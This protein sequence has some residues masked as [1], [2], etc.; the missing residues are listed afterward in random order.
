MEI[1]VPQEVLD[2]MMDKMDQV[3]AFLSRNQ[4]DADQKRAMDS[5]GNT[6][7]GAGA[8]SGKTTVLS[9]RFVRLLLE[10][11]ELHA[12]NILA[13]TF[14]N[15]AAK[16]MKA[17]IANH[18]RR[19]SEADGILSE[20]TRK[21]FLQ[22]W[23]NFF[24]RSQICTLDSFCSSIVRIDCLQYGLTSDFVVDEEK[25]RA[26]FRAIARKLLWYDKGDGRNLLVSLNK[27][28][29][30]L[31]KLAEMAMEEFWL[32]GTL[33]A[34]QYVQWFFDAVE[35]QKKQLKGRLETMFSM[36]Y[37]AEP[38][39]GDTQQVFRAL[40]KKAWE[41]YMADHD[42]DA[43]M[44]AGLLASFKAIRG[45]K[46]GLVEVRAK[47]KD[48]F[49]AFFSA[50]NALNT[51]FL[52]QG[53]IAA[54]AGFFAQYHDLCQA[55][56][57]RQG[58]LCYNDLIHLA[59]DILKKN[60]GVRRYFAK[61]YR[62]IMVDE[63]Q[64][65]NDLQKQLV[66]L[67]AAKDSYEGHDVPPAEMLDEKLFFVGDEKQSIYRFRGAD[68]SVF[69]QLGAELAKRDGTFVEMATNYR[70]EGFLIDTFT[71]MFT[72]IMENPT[73]AY[74]AVFTPLGSV[75]D[76]PE[77]AT[78]TIMLGRENENEDSD[79][80]DL[81][82]RKAWEAKAVACKIDGMLH[83]DD[84]LVSDRKGSF[85]RPRPNDIA[86][87]MHTSGAQMLYEKALRSKGIPYEISQIS[88]SLPLESVANDIYSVLQLLVYPSDKIAY[89]AVLRSPFCRLKDEEVEQVLRNPAVFSPEACDSPLYLQACSF[90]QEL[91]TR[92]TTMAMPDLLDYLWYA[93]GY[94]LSLLAY[95][96]FQVYLDH[97]TNLRQLAAEAADAGMGIP[98]FLDTIRP[99]LG[100]SNKIELRSSEGI[101]E[102]S[103]QGV[104]IM[105]IHASK[106]LEFPIVFVPDLSYKLDKLNTDREHPSFVH[107]Q[108]KSVPP[109]VE[110]KTD[111]VKVGFLLDEKEKK[112]QVAEAKRLYY[113]A[114][115]RAE[116]HLV[117]SGMYEKLTKNP[118]EDTTLL[119]MTLDALGIDKEHVLSLEREEVDPHGI[120]LARISPIS[121]SEMQ[122]RRSFSTAGK[123]IVSRWYQKSPFAP[124]LDPSR[125]SVTSYCAPAQV[126]ETL[127]TLPASPADEILGD[128]SVLITG[129]G[130]YVHARTM[131]MMGIYALDK[132]RDDLAQDAFKDKS[133]KKHVLD[134][135]MDAG[136]QLAE[137]FLESAYYHKE[138]EPFL[139]TT[140]AEVH[141][142]FHPE[143]A[144]NDDL[145]VE[146]QIDVLIK[147]PDGYDI[148]DF[149]TD[150]GRTQ[151]GHK[152]QVTLYKEALKQITHC[153]HIR[154]AIVYLRDPEH[155]VY[156]E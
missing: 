128:D 150:R 98:A 77:H 122:S 108:G 100:K 82:H 156:W 5:N 95:P 53:Q 154:T 7:V 123:E 153:D 103:Q 143:D 147:K 34:T 31:E 84:Y 42:F 144:D 124:N 135:L 55:F 35:S 48:D 130:T 30:L 58:I 83:G 59:I 106:G 29:V 46:G 17:R 131:Q 139:A 74:E 71:T 12:D 79:E 57:T 51:I 65:N 6:V 109:I 28:D 136:D 113:V 87:L 146:G 105:T 141:L 91:K 137:K 41:R 2:T 22:E 114:V 14:T 47:I 81:A 9:Y 125:I 13:L 120:R 134:R 75:N 69:K 23:T 20:E 115:T 86:I 93:T 18:I 27:P 92:A 44:D 16:E 88:R 54:V 43:M 121:E 52:H 62:Y 1:C 37:A 15:K 61:K 96:N 64:D 11:P 66:Y 70:S 104:K 152:Q 38:G 80:D 140:K 63:F 72:K 78:I 8:G 68:V 85:R 132:S 112:Q 145:V 142:F 19:L 148:L 32:P 126:D 90:F 73:E 151:N 99:L 56:K 101:L 36:L 119:G 111:P 10:N 149:K 33:N 102:E 89:H 127:Q 24:P 118:T 67:L 50:Y 107:L 25:C 133:L 110:G 155:V 3:M 60:V 4:L 49:V 45:K 40:V 26:Q 21:H 116:Q 117:L 94:R 129:W 39:S 76:H 138:I 97:Y